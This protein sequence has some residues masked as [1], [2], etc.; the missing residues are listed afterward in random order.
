MLKYILIGIAL[1]TGW[2]SY[3]RYHSPKAVVEPIE[4][5]PEIRVVTPPSWYGHPPGSQPTAS[6]SSQS[7]AA[8]NALP[9]FVCDGRTYCSQMTSCDEAMFFLANCPGTKMDNNGKGNGI[10]CERQWCKR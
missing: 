3:Q 1:L 6:P 2:L 7:P 4:T 5:A 10:P 9:K 8:T